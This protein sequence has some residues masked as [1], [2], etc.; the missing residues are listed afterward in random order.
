M[1][2]LAG[3]IAPAVMLRNAPGANATAVSQL[4]HGEGFAVLDIADGWAWG[5]GLHDHYVGY[6]PAGALGAFG[7]V[8]HVVRAVRAPVFATADIKAPV[9]AFWPI[10]ARFAGTE[11]GDFIATE[12]G[13]VHTRHAGAIAAPEADPVAVAERLIGTPYLWGGRGGD[14]V[15]CSGLVQLALGLAGIAA[16]RDSDQQQA[17]GTALADDAPLRRGDLLFFPG[18]VGLMVDAET[19]V[20]ANAHAMAVTIEPLAEIIARLRPAYAE[21]ILARRRMDG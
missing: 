19:M 10:G 15:D 14:G 2:E 9:V 4:L 13:Y 6:V 21:P 20:H 11:E 12:E 7:E 5:Y 17:L 3:C 18:H 1:P 16:P 8:S